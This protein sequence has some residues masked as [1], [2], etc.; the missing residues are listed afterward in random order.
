MHEAVFESG[1]DSAA[2]I[3]QPWGE[4]AQAY[5]GRGRPVISLDWTLSHHERGPKI[6]AVTKSYDYV[7]RRMA[8]SLEGSDGGGIQPR[9]DRWA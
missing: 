5:Q 4:V 2:F 9:M 7:E 1:W 8:L 6:Y 3:Q